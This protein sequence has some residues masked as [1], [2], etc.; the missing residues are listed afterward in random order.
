MSEYSTT[1]PSTGP[2]SPLFGTATFSTLSATQ[3]P[4][5]PSIFSSSVRSATPIA[6]SYDSDDASSGRQMRRIMVSPSPTSRDSDSQTYSDENSIID[7]AEVEAAISLDDVE[8][9]IT[10]MEDHLSELSRGSSRSRSPSTY[11]SYTGPSTYTSRSGTSFSGTASGSTFTSSQISGDYRS[12]TAPMTR[13]PSPANLIGC[14]GTRKAGHLLLSM[15][16]RPRIRVKGPLRPAGRILYQAG[17]SE[18]L[19]LPL[20]TDLSRRVEAE[21]SPMAIRGRCRPHLV[22][23]L[24]VR[25]RHPRAVPCPH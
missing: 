16:A 3:T 4:M 1:A 19:L 14:L 22:H 11:T 13:S 9:Q 20:K 12:T 25:I 2:R 8:D 24:P 21:V 15:C 6:S 7:E 10:E 23:G 5:S 18:S 17:A